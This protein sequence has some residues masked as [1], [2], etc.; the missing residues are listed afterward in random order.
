[1]LRISVFLFYAIVFFGTVFSG[2]TQ[3]LDGENMMALAQTTLS[4]SIV[5]NGRAHLFSG[6]LL[7]PFLGRKHAWVL[8][9]PPGY[10]DNPTRE[11]PV[12]YFIHGTTSGSTGSGTLPSALYLFNQMQAGNGLPF[13]VAWP[14]VGPNNMIGPMEKFF[15]QTFM[16]YVENRFR[17]SRHPEHTA[18]TGH[19][20]GGRVATMSALKHPEKFA[21]FYQHGNAASV[22]D[23]SG[24]PTSHYNA[25]LHEVRAAMEDGFQDLRPDS[26]LIV[27]DGNVSNN[28]DDWRNLYFIS[29]FMQVYPDTLEPPCPHTPSCIWEQAGNRILPWLD[30]QWIP[31][32]RSESQNSTFVGEEGISDTVFFRLD[33]APTASVEVL[34]QVPA[35]LSASSGSLTFTTQDWNQPKALVL[36]GVDD[37]LANGERWEVVRFS[38]VS[39][40]ARFHRRRMF[41]LRVLVTDNE[42]PSRISFGRIGKLTNPPFRSHSS[43]YNVAEQ[44]NLES[45][46]FVWGDTLVH[47]KRQNVTLALHLSNPHPQQSTKV[48][49][50]LDSLRLGQSSPFTPYFAGP[51][52]LNGFTDTLVIFPPGTRLKEIILPPTIDARNEGTEI[53]QFSLTCLEGGRNAERGKFPTANLGL[54]D[55]HLNHAQTG[56]ALI[57]SEFS[58]GNG[59]NEAVLEIFNPD[60]RDVGSSNLKLKIMRQPGVW[61]DSVGFLLLPNGASIHTGEVMVIGGETTNDTLREKLDLIS[62][63]LNQLTGNEVIGLFRG[64]TLVDVIG[65]PGQTTTNGWRAGG[66]NGATRGTILRKP[67]VFQ[68]HNNFASEL[69][70][71]SS[72]SQWIAAPRNYRENLGIHIFQRIRPGRISNA[73]PADPCETTGLGFPQTEFQEIRLY[74]NPGHDEFSVSAGESIQAIQLLDLEGK[75]VQQGLVSGKDGKIN[76]EGQ[77]RGMYLLRIKTGSSVKTLKLLHH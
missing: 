14:S 19:S 65:V 74:P 55:F 7:N 63:A 5:R 72:T 42:T 69:S 52:D 18:I 37:N 11:Y 17:I 54:S 53:A 70:A 66:L 44:A 71:D 3:N 47:S 16:P 77:P 67:S 43:G 27:R 31:V 39:G 59:P 40:D 20:M 25:Y 6:A 38:I 34:V 49:V 22:I 62:P 50:I 1:M 45:R 15:F 60:Y 73:N 12:L 68:T 64:T 33:K 56:N 28:G 2:R 30:R 10:Y 26:T 32:L 41:N 8:L 9:L 23:N 58:L 36:Q 13:I 75:F 48:R 21:A 61:T 35:G 24:K 46:S 29:Q 76:L 51:E 4:D 57:I